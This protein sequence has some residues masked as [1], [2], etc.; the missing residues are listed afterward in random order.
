[1]NDALGHQAGDD[2]LLGIAASLRDRLRDSDLIGRLGG[3]EFVVVLAEVGADEAARVAGQLRE[4]VREEGLAASSEHVATASV[5]VA[6]FDGASD[7]RALL[8]RADQA[9]YEA[10][11]DGGNRVAI[12]AGTP[13]P[14]R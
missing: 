8:N 12:G 11:R 7:Q 14:A 6:L 4:L 10:K 2:L 1:V 3:D 9:M 13:D 5:G